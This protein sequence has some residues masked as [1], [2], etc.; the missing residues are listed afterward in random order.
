M[1]SLY[2]LSD[3]VAM[4]SIAACRRDIRAREDLKQELAGFKA[5][6][7]RGDFLSAAGKY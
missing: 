7:R 3:L 1:H 4:E 5:G 6:G 2:Q